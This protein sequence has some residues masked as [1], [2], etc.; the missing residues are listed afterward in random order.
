MG[1]SDAKLVPV[2]GLRSRRPFEFLAQCS[3]LRVFWLSQFGNQPGNT[4]LSGLEVVQLCGRLGPVP[5]PI[6]L[7]S[8]WFYP[9]WSLKLRSAGITPNLLS[10][11]RSGFAVFECLSLVEVRLHRALWKDFF[12]VLFHGVVGGARLLA[13]EAFTR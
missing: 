12:N 2:T 13:S 11:E 1:P 4:Q 9:S 6:T 5:V 10:L 8:H 3:Y 7:D